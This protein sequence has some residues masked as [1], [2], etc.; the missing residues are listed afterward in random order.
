MY[1]YFEPLI[2]KDGKQE[3][4]IAESGEYFED[5]GQS[6]VLRANTKTHVQLSLLTMQKFEDDPLREI[7]RLWNLG[8]PKGISKK[9]MWQ[10]ISAVM[11]RMK[12]GE[13]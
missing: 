7:K 4:R 9:A 8:Y 11:E 6:G 2:G 1:Y 5:Y 3:V 10:A 13:R 12:E